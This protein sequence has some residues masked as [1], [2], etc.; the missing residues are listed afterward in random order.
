MLVRPFVFRVCLFLVV[1]LPACD[2]SNCICSYVCM[3]AMCWM[4]AHTC[5]KQ[6]W[7]SAA[8]LLGCD[9]TG[10]KRRKRSERIELWHWNMV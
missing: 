3:Y 8:A 1:S 4:D 6:Y 10:M 2:S 9:G 7:L 5:L